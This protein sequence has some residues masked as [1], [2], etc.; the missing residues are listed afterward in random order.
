MTVNEHFDTGVADALKAAQ[1][2]ANELG[3]SIKVDGGWVNPSFA[4]LA[5]R[6]KA[7]TDVNARLHDEFKTNR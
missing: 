4:S 5:K 7:S 2:K 6:P 1:L 3:R